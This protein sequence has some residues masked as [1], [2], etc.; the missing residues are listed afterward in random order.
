MDK[1]YVIGRWKL[2]AL[3]LDYSSH[4]WYMAGTIILTD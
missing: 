2:P 1:K 4:A 3:N